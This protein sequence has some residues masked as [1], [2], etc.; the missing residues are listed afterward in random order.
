[1]EYLVVGLLVILILFLGYVL[2]DSQHQNA[3]L[4]SDM[5]SRLSGISSQLLET[6]GRIDTRLENANVTIINVQERLGELSEASRRIREIGEDISSLQDILRPPKARG[7]LGEVMLTE[8][9]NQMLPANFQSQ[10]TFASGERVDAVIKLGGK[11]VPIDA[12]FSLDSF[13]R[14]LDAPDAEGQEKHKNQFARDLKKHA[15]DIA[16][17]YILPDEGTYEFA[18]MYLPSERI[19]YEVIATDFGGNVNPADYAVA[20]KVIPVSPRTL[21]AYLQTIMLGL[22]GLCVEEKAAEIIELLGRLRGD[23]ARFTGDFEIVGTHLTNAH[24]KYD[25]ATKRLAKLSGKL[26]MVETMGEET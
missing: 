22:R 18:L 4:R 20:K 1:M 8:L 21:F 7:V 9:L 3:R 11:L 25:E 23:M 13:R 5:D 16:A 10:H 2:I 14:M 24:G 19:Y 12:K 15:D 26:D 17:K 6:T